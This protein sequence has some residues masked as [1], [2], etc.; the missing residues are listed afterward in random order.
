MLTPNRP[1]LR[2]LRGKEPLTGWVSL[3]A[4]RDPERAKRYEQ[5]LSLFLGY[6]DPG[7]PKPDWADPSYL[8][9]S[10]K[11]LRA[12]RFA[13][14]EFFEFVA[15][16][17][18][19]IVAPHEVTRRDAFDYAEWLLHRGKGGSHAR[20]DFSLAE[21]RLKDGDTDDELAVFEAVKGGAR[22]LSEVARVLP[23]S[24]RR[25]HPSP[26]RSGDVDAAWLEDR[27]RWLMQKKLLVRSPSYAVLR[28]EK[29]RAGLGQEVDPDT[30]VYAV[31]RLEPCARA[32]AY[33]RLAALS[34][35]WRILQ[36]GENNA[37]HALLD[38]NVFEDA[39]SA[40]AKGLGDLK[41][42]SSVSRRPT[43]ELIARLFSAAKGSRLPDKRN[44][45]LLW[46]L[47][48]C[49][50]RIDET[51]NLRRAEPPT[52]SERKRYP[53]WLDLSTDPP[54][55]VVRRKARRVQRL[56]VPPYV[57][58]AL[59]E[60]WAALAERGAGARPDEP[61]Y[62][63]Q[64]LVTQ[65]DAPLFPSLALWGRNSPLLTENRYGQWSYRKALGQPAVAMLLERLAVR[66]GMTELE[67]RR[68]HPHGFRHAAAE[69]MLFGGM[70]IRDVQAILGH[71]SIQTTEDYLPDADVSKVNGQAAVLEWLEKKGQK[72]AAPAEE[73][74]AP[75]PLAVIET[76][77][78]EV[79]PLPRQAAARGPIE[80]EFEPEPAEVLPECRVVVIESECPPRPY[81]VPEDA[82]FGPGAPKMPLLPPGRP[83]GRPRAVT[84]VGALGSSANP[85]GPYEE[86]E[87][88][89]KPSD[90]VWSGRPKAVF[91]E[92]HY[93]A[94]PERFGLGKQSL[95]VWWNKDAPLPW[96]VLAPVQAYPELE[97]GGFLAG[98]ERLYDEWVD[99]SPTKAQ[100]LAQWYFYLGSVT[101]GLEHRL[102]GAYSWVSF[103]A[104]ATVGEDLR[105]HDS[106]WLLGWFRQNAALFTVAQR[107][108]AAIG[109]PLPGEETE[110]YWERIREPAQVASL[111]PTVPKLPEWFFEDDP[112]RAIY[113]RDPEEWKAF[114]RWISGLTGA[115]AS[116][117]RERERLEQRD[118]TDR[119]REAEHAR[120]QGLLE[121]YY[122]VLDDFLRAQSPHEKT[123]LRSELEAL[124][125]VLE[126]AY[127][128]VI[129][130]SSERHAERI[131]RLLGKAFP[132]R[133]ARPRKNVL[134]DARM[135]RPEAFRIDSSAHTIRHT[136]E[137]RR[138][139]AAEQYGRDSECIMRRVARALWEKV[140]DVRYGK[141]KPKLTPA[142]EQRELFVTLLATMAFV[143]P[144]PA[145]VE[146][147]LRA[148]GKR[149]LRPAEIARFVEERM[150]Q[151]ASGARPETEIDEVAQDIVESYLEHLPAEVEPALRAEIAHQ[152]AARPRHD[153]PEKKAARRR[154]RFEP[155]VAALHANAA[156][157]L[158][159][160]L[161]LV[162]SSF[163]PV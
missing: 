137:F 72:P 24:V 66:A 100:A 149:S 121:Q 57:L 47:L 8:E 159:H 68:I 139:F 87:R 82:P 51:L 107:R 65:P 86:L 16:A 136:A 36:K 43:P 12:Y 55:F 126:K 152:Q 46:T 158:P 52:E 77:G 118:W 14:A 127:G 83:E 143:V 15:R 28:E 124:A 92:E 106:A 163:W 115:S 96:P 44:L 125:A 103:N 93:P 142:E 119:C 105:A 38:Y 78:A 144:C 53:G 33:V 160:P 135:F 162:A 131:D 132:D 148:G 150:R 7:G 157:V 10:P 141:E 67:R 114:A 95:L 117:E 19:K 91:L 31:K 129:P 88:G 48:L 151:A 94:L 35:F 90:L 58:S 130:K 37:A 49:G 29:P 45:A 62:R 17:H 99:E 128:I 25:A 64:L 4:R 140:R 79:T 108:Y 81:G 39:L 42:E 20:F 97:T 84:E 155:N 133:P 70:G 134:G 18:G 102:G 110:A 60:L 13:V 56:A 123:A 3:F 138:V 146:A 147:A 61:A 122:S 73:R 22:R 6:R 54:S 74:P 1:E 21:E 11:T 30:Y 27:L 153:D 120:A 69:G 80:A 89:R 23:A 34:A 5:A 111:I 112:V 2:A 32:T 154:G 41:H 71:R 26:L 9:R 104:E 76:A 113:E 85:V 50:T 40:A 63:C 156:R 59:K 116:E 145:D 98:L 161:R 75:R 109:K 101:A